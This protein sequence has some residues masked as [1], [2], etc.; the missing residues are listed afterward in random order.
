MAKAKK[1]RASRTDRKLARPDKPARGRPRQ[2]LLPGTEDHA[3]KPLED[4]AA[5][6]AEVRDE[7]MDLNKR[8]HELK[9][10]ALKLMK[11]YEKTIYRRDGIEIRVVAGEDDVKVRIK[12]PGEEESED[13]D[14]QVEIDADAEGDADAGHATQL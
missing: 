8:E 12:K 5:S 7:R 11:K 13:A 9:Q 6:Y 10:H 2:A 3:I 1:K 14:D 4:V